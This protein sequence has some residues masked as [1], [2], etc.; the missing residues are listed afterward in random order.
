[1][2]ALVLASL[3][4]GTAPLQPPPPSQV[5]VTTV[6][7]RA[8]ESDAVR[9]QRL[10][11]LVEAAEQ[12]VEASDELTAAAKSEEADVLTAD[13]SPELLNQADVQDLLLRLKEVQEQIPDGEAAEPEPGLKAPEEVVSISGA[14]RQ[15]RRLRPGQAG[16]RRRGRAIGPR[17]PGRHRIGVP[18]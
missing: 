16:L 9:I 10:R 4:W 14:E 7:A 5:P 3:L 8:A 18:Q 17:L 11:S 15:R 6:P 12:A 2:P 1:M 13:W